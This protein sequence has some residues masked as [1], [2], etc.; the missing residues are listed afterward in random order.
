MLTQTVSFWF[1]IN[2]SRMRDRSSH[3]SDIVS[4]CLQAREDN[5]ASAY[6]FMGLL[7]ITG[8]ENWVFECWS[9]WEQKCRG[10]SENLV[11]SLFWKWNC[12]FLISVLW[13]M[14]KM[15]RSIKSCVCAE[16]D[17]TVLPDQF[18]RKAAQPYANET[19]Q[20]YMKTWKIKLREVK[21][22]FWTSNS[23]KLLTQ[24]CEL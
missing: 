11:C 21:A 4:S 24:P 16:V 17:V 20:K 22:G 13:K 7:V 18:W 10:T 12:K 14:S 5:S 23:K 8:K 3:P 9:R 2:S 19:A 6:I 15:E 1:Q